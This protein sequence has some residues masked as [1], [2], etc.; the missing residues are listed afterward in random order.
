M[1]DPITYFEDGVEKRL[2]ENSV[3]PQ[4]M[5]PWHGFPI[6]FSSSKISRRRHSHFPNPFLIFYKKGG[7]HNKISSGINSYIFDTSPGSTILVQEGFEA[8]RLEFSYDDKECISTTLEIK[9]CKL[10]QLFH[11]ESR[12][13]DLNGVQVVVDGTIENLLSL[14]EAE[15]RNDCR[16]GRLYAESLSIA[17]V[18]YLNEHYA[19]R[20]PL[21][22]TQQKFSAQ[23][24][25][26]LTSYIQENL[27][28][29][30]SVVELAGIVHLSP[31]HFSRIFKAS[32]NIKPHRF[33]VEHRLLTAQRLL[34]SRLSIDEIAYA[35][36]FASQGHL[37]TSFR[38]R[39]GVSP[40]RARNHCAFSIGDFP[41]LKAAPE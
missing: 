9:A 7:N 5:N 19:V 22:R 14:M 6:E 2:D 41:F 30:L 29:D 10:S 34:E 24:V 28:N 32:L 25:E 40:T 1:K 3:I 37:S 20:K 33:I 13:I 31:F 21:G 35:T 16:S 26:K 38:K 12:K 23:T 18:S 11:N 4:P 39:F 8:E 17:F 15:I 36:G 27:A